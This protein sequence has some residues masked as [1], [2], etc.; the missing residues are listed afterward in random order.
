MHRPRVVADLNAGP[1]VYRIY[2]YKVTCDYLVA[3]MGARLIFGHG[4][5]R[6]T[7]LHW[8]PELGTGFELIPRGVQIPAHYTLM[9]TSCGLL[10]YS[11]PGKAFAFQKNS[12]SLR[13]L[14]TH[15]W[16]SR[17]TLIQ[18]GDRN[19][20]TSA[21]LRGRSSCLSGLTSALGSPKRALHS[22]PS[23]QG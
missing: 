15:I 16:D 4:C 3:R 9:P 10:I 17:H 14:H 5:F 1:K 12:N 8:A 22:R 18:V 6:G 23:Q 19:Y 13:R 2:K 21:S 7:K 11:W 20:L